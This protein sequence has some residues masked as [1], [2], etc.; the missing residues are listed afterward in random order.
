MEND[1]IRYDSVEFLTLTFTHTE[2]DGIRNTA[3]EILTVN[4]GFKGLLLSSER[5]GAPLPANRWICMY[6]IKRS[7]Q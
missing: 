3:A 6:W 7:S 2:T 1:G 5:L 4:D